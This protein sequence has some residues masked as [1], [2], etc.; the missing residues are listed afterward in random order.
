MPA[1]DTIR[2]RACQRVQLQPCQM[3]AHAHMRSLAEPQMPVL[4]AGDIKPGGI[5]GHR[6]KPYGSADGFGDVVSCS[7]DR[8]RK[9]CQSIRHH[10]GRGYAALAAM[11]F[12]VGIKR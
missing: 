5:R 9:A 11:T 10:S 6:V 3:H 7:L 2:H 8:R 1:C 12:S 4:L